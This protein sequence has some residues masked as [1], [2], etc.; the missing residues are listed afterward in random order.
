MKKSLIILFLLSKWVLFSQ[1]EPQKKI[2][3]DSLYREDQFYFTITNNS[4]QNGPKNFKQN[5]FSLGLA[6]GFLRDMPINKKRNFSIAAGFGYSIIILNQNIKITEA[7]SEKTYSVVENSNYDKNKLSL[8]YIDF[9]LEIRWR[10]SNATDSQF[11]RIYSGF[12]FSYMVYNQ[13]KFESTNDIIS[14]QNIPEVN[15]VQYGVYLSA[16]WDTFNIYLYYGLNPIFKSA[17][18][19]NEAIK[20]NT[21]NF[22]LQFY[23]L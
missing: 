13:Y 2:E 16:G 21:F 5:R 3:S 15:K 8:H 19:G 7:E 17:F 12:K 20:T 10:T 4:L 6:T 18:V 14:L 9:P 11:W 23:I 22:G 1:T